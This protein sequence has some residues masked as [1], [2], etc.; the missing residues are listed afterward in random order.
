MAMHSQRNQLALTLIRNLELAPADLAV[1]TATECDRDDVQVEDQ[2]LEL[3]VLSD[4]AH[5]T[6]CRIMQALVDAHSGIDAAMDVLARD[7]STANERETNRH[8]LSETLALPRDDESQSITS[9]HGERHLHRERATVAISTRFRVLGEHARGG[10]GKVSRAFDKELAREVALKEMQER[11]GGDLDSQRRFVTEAEV[12]G[13]LEHPGVVPVYSLGWN[14]NGRPYYA[15][16]FIRGESLQETVDRFHGRSHQEGVAAIPRSHAGVDYFSVEFRKLL[17]RM[18]DVCQAVEY[19]HSRGVL[20]RDLKPS[21]VMLGPYGETLVVDWGLAKVRDG[22]DDVGLG[23][24]ELAIRPNA[25]AAET[26]M[27]TVMGTPRFMSP[28]QA[29][30]QMDNL[31][32]TAD[33]Y[34]LGAMLFYL[35]TG[36]HSVTGGDS[37]AVVSQVARGDIL[38]ARE[39]ND[40][41]PR[42]LESICRK[43][44]A[45]ASEDR[46]QSANEIGDEIE[47]WLAD[48]PV[49]AHRDSTVVRVR[50]WLRKHQTLA[51]S[52]SASVSVAIVGLVIGL[53]AFAGLNGRLAAAN[54]DLSEA[55]RLE[56]RLRHQAQES[57]ANALARKKDA[58]DN[59]QLAT[60]AVEKYLTE[61]DDDDG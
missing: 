36:A 45:R 15:M 5:S 32:P 37:R 58:D 9:V 47:R 60:E 7:D 22:S 19:A 34:S 12:T 48:E 2:L 51:T 3:G 52:F 25:A 61:I 54:A 55:N 16:R 33:T 53:F 50:R 1:A 46:Y 14:E 35:L 18:V 49:L 8:D 30:G 42:P 40:H 44:M 26:E 41:V 27:G 23:Q 43:A 29:S 4:A 57:E 24:E 21:N 59:F 6:F 17:S 28:E 20:H 11:H 56:S 38:S 31:G 13:Q 10:L 39:I